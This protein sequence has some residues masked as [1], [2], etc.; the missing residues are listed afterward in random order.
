MNHA[1][2]Y[3]LSHSVSVRPFPCLVC[4][5]GDVITVIKRVDENWGEGKLGD[6]VGIFPLQ[7]T[8]V[9]HFHIFIQTPLK[10]YLIE[11]CR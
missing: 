3:R 5:Q 2:V 9:R 4:T 8:E 7:F 6:K 1:C 11:P 10:L